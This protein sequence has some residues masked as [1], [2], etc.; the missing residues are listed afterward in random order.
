MGLR[1]LPAKDPSQV[2]EHRS[3]VV[4]DRHALA[5]HEF[6]SMTQVHSDSTYPVSGIKL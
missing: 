6:W 1:D 4:T 5:A 3:M 2:R